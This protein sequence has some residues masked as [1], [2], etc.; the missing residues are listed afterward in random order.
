MI[1]GYKQGA[2]GEGASG[3]GDLFSLNFKAIATGETKLEINR[4]NFRNPEGIRLQ[5]VPEA[6][7]IEVR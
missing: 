4:V 3:S 1:V 7:M 6:I 5:V 2:G